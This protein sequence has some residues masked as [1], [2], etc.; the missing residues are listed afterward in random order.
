MVLCYFNYDI[1]TLQLYYTDIFT[2]HPFS[3]SS[4]LRVEPIERKL[5][6]CWAVPCTYE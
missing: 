6:C 3:L 1:Y 2:A 5:M 4:L